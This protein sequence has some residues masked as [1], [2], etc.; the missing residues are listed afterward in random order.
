MSNFSIPST[1]SSD[2]P[3]DALTLDHLQVGEQGKIVA[4][5]ADTELK[6]RLAAL[7]LRMGCT[8]HVLRKAGFGGPVHVRVGTTEVIMR[9]NEAKRILATPWVDLSPASAHKS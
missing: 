4:I 3:D 1:H 8:F 2:L 9:L 6:Q 7:G 5:Q